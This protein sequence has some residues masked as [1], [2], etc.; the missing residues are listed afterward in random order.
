MTRKWKEKEEREKMTC[1][2]GGGE[3]RIEELLSNKMKRGQCQKII[4]DAK[5]I[6]QTI[7]R[8]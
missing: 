8:N 5:V 2:D 6:K 3:K 7:R 4:T 1:E